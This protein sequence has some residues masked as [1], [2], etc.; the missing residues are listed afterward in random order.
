MAVVCDHKMVDDCPYYR[1]NQDKALRWLKLKINY[2]VE[3]LKK[4][5]IDVSPSVTRVSNF[6]SGRASTFT[7]LQYL[8][9][10]LDLITHYVP[11]E[12]V[13]PLRDALKLQLNE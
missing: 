7:T 12:L 10:A 4:L 8:K 5:S 9:Y 2:I 1:Y 3:S 13:D 11:K 6:N